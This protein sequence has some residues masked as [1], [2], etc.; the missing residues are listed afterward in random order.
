[1]KG[2]WLQFTPKEDGVGG[3]VTHLAIAAHMDDIEIMAVDGI[4]KA[5]ADPELRFAGVVVTDSRGAPRQGEFAN[6]TDE[7][8]AEI[9]IGEQARAAEIGNYAACV[10]MGYPS[11]A[12]K[13]PNNKELIKDL[14]KVIEHF[15]PEVVYTHSLADK[16]ST[17][18]AVCLRVIK[19]LRR[20]PDKKVK[21]FIGCEVWRGLDW[22]P[23]DE[24]VLMDV[25]EN[26]DL[27][28]ALLQAHRS[29]TVGGKNYLEAVMGRRTANATFLDPHD[30]DRAKGLVYGMD[31]MPLLDDPQLDP[32]E[33]M[34]AL[35]RRFQDEV[36]EMIRGLL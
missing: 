31:L 34:R 10:L 3:K 16:H 29:Q 32:L 4:L 8:M 36:L 22:L 13:K 6:V 19:A 12:V 2:H 9:R 35:T 14:V 15:D 21:E 24:K 11:V 30:T 17:H 23:D 1:M 18:V 33:Y 28:K 20:T 25:S 26:P 7:E 5:Q 27:Q